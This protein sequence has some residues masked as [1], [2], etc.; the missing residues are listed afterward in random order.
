MDTDPDARF[1]RY[2]STYDIKKITRKEL[3]ELKTAMEAA[4]SDSEISYIT[5]A[6]QYVKQR[7][8]EWTKWAKKNIP[9]GPPKQHTL[10]TKKSSPRSPIS[11]KVSAVSYSSQFKYSF[12]VKVEEAFGEKEVERPAPQKN[13]ADDYYY[14]YQCMSC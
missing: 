6:Q 11:P 14:Y 7:E 9:G 1:A 10:E 13:E 8:A 12:F 4:I 2:N 3:A 5:L